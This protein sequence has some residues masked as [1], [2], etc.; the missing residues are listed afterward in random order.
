MKT[1][2]QSPAPSLAR[3]VAGEDLSVDEYIAVLSTTGQYLSH[4]WDRCDLPPE[5]VVRVRYVP[6][7]AGVPLKIFG[8]CLPFVY[9][10]RSNDVIEIIDMRMTQVARLD[11]DAAREIW[12]Q[13][14]EKPGKINV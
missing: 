13:L 14:K 4:D 12:K 3:C 9:A 1:S 7:I 10:R 11:K 8:I 6:T 2:E 5:E